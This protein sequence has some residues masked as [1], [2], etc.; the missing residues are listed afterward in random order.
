[1]QTDQSTLSGENVAHLQAALAE[2]EAER[3][4]VAGEIAAAPET[5]HLRFAGTVG[6]TDV[7]VRGL[8]SVDVS[9]DNST[10]DLLIRTRDATIR[11]KAPVRH[12]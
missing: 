6:N 11:V 9:Y 12:P 4:A 5:Q 10:G 7:E 3:V 1:L 2:A 8:S